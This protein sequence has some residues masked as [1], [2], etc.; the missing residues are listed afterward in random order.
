MITFEQALHL[1]YGQTLYDCTAKNADGSPRRWRVAGKVKTWKRNPDRVEIPV[2]Y[3]LY[4][5]G[6]ITNANLWAVALTQDEAMQVINRV[7][8]QIR[9]HDE[10]ARLRSHL[11]HDHQGR[12][13]WDVIV[14]G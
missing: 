2:K 3:G 14:T 1:A 6:R 11:I 10:I 4:T 12:V 5:W 9:A 7:D 13:M 8:D